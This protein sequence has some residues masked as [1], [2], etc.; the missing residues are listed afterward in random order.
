ML[1][2]PDV[3]HRG[4]VSRITQE[5]DVRAAIGE[6]DQ[7]AVVSHQT[8]NPG[9]V[10]V[11][12]RTLIAGLE[13]VRDGKIEVGIYRLLALQLSDPLDGLATVGGQAWVVDLQHRRLPPDMVPLAAVQFLTERFPEL[14]LLVQGNL[15]C[16]R[17]VEGW[18][19]GEK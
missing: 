10:I 5:I 12:Q 19:P 9:L 14:C 3:Q 11:K 4:G 7:E 15:F 8:L 1:P 16:H 17:A 13:I 6:P 18:L 2:Y